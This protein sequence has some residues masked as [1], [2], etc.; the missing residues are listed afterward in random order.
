MSGSNSNDNDNNNN[1]KNSDNYRWL[2]NLRKNEEQRRK[3]SKWFNMQPG[4][5]TVLEFLPE[6]GPTWKDFDGDGIKETL[7]YEYKV[8]DINRRENGPIPW[9]VSKRWSST[10]DYYLKQGIHLLKVE[11]VGAGMKTNY[12]FMPVEDASHAAASSS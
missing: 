4:E 3:D 7:R 5:K 2:E 1:N 11:R 9:D 10:I 12:Y 8:I 6:F